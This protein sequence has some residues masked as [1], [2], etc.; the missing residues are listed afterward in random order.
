MTVSQIRSNIRYNENL[1]DEYT[2]ERR[3]LEKQIEEL[4]ALGDKYGRLQTRFGDRQQL[5]QSKLAA[6]LSSRIQNQILKQYYN[7]MSQLL[8]GSDFNNAYEGLS[9]AKRIINRKI[10]ELDQQLEDCKGRIAYRKQ[11]RDY[12]RAQLAAAL[13]KE[14]G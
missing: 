5:R 9:E 13:A 12:W 1:I 7:G 2:R 10:L 6:F 14:E 4:E 8:G 11:R 3:E